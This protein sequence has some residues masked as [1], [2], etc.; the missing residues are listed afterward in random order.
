MSAQLQAPAAPSTDAPLAEPTKAEFF[1]FVWSHM[2]QGFRGWV[3]ALAGVHYVQSGR[4]WEQIEQPDRERLLAMMRTMA[5]D[6]A[7]KTKGKAAA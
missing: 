1:A 7:K 4:E 2:H 3:C 6:R 5:A